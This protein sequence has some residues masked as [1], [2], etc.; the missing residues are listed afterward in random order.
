M[1][2]VSR[3]FPELM[4]ALFERK[5]AGPIVPLRARYRDSVTED[6]VVTPA[7]ECIELVTLWYNE[8]VDYGVTTRV[9]TIRREL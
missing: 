1:A 4:R 5:H 6:I 7:G 3:D 8:Y 2:T 9:I